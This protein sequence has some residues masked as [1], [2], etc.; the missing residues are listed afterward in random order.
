VLSRA[1]SACAAEIVSPVTRQPVVR[2]ACG[3]LGDCVALG[4]SFSGPLAIRLA[5]APPANL[6]GVILVATFAS[7]P[8]PLGRWLAP[9]LRAPLAHGG[10]LA[11][12]LL[13]SASGE[14]GERLRRDKRAALARLPAATLAC[15]IRSV[16]RVDVRQALRA[17]NLPMLAFASTRDLVVPGWNARRLRRLQPAVELERLPG[18]HLALYTAAPLAAARI[19]AFAARVAPGAAP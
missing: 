9:L 14:L 8:W 12:R 1:T 17:C 18:G 11:S 7:P 10:P 15:R 19:A 4:W 13:G 5:A 3:R 6:R 2:A 16:L